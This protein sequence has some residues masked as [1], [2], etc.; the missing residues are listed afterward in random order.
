MSKA[1]EQGRYHVT[2]NGTW[3]EFVSN[4]LDAAKTKAREL[5][6]RRATFVFDLADSIYYDR[7]VFLSTPVSETDFEGLIAVQDS[8]GNVFWRKPTLQDV[9]EASR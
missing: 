3:S 1:Q 9:W 2:V 4:D 5:G 6:K 8:D 7:P